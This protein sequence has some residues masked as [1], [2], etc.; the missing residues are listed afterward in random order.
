MTKSNKLIEATK[1]GKDLEASNNL[2]AADVD[3]VTQLQAD[4]KLM[5]DKAAKR[6]VEALA[7]KMDLAIQ[8]V[9]QFHAAAKE[10]VRR[11]RTVLDSLT[12]T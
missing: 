8:E 7:V 5:K 6:P 9:S 1:Q 11:I 12:Q 10:K 3:R 4:Y 2:I